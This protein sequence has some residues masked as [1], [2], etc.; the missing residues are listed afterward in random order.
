MVSDEKLTAILLRI[1]MW[2]VTYLL[3]SFRIL[4]ISSLIMVCLGV[5]LF[6]LIL[7]VIS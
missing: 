7:F 1:Y 2:Q 3:A 4:L 6:E 5:D